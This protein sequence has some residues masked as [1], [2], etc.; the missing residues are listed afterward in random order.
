M[1]VAYL[2]H[3]TELY[4]ANRSLI[5]LV[6][7]L[8]A[9]GEV[10]PLVV[11]PREGPLLEFLRDA[12]I[13][14][15]VFPFEPWMSERRYSGRFY[16]KLKQWWGYEQAAMTRA[17]NNV[18]T[19]PGLAQ[20]VKA[21]RASLVH[22]NSAAVSVGAA[23]AREAGVPLVQHVREMPEKHYRLHLDMGRGAY[24]D[25]LQ[26]ADRVIAISHAAAEDLKR[27]APSARV[28]VAYNGVLRRSR[29]AEFAQQAEERW[30]SP[31]PIRFVMVGLLH[32]GKRYDEA[33]DAVRAV[34]AQGHDVRLSIAGGGRDKDLVAHIHRAGLQDVVELLGYVEDPFPLFRQAHALVMCS[35]DEAMGR[36]TVEAMAS[37]LPVIGHAS[38]ATP[39]LVRDGITGL[40]YTDGPEA[41]AAC[42]LELLADLH[43]AR[44]MGR[45]GMEE[46]AQ[47]FT[48]EGYATEVMNV[49]RDILPDGAPV[50]RP[51]DDDDALRT[52]GR[53]W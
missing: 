51:S 5:D 47:R 6:L 35:R 1:R 39:E 7:E 2:T 42:M 31:S 13:T 21:Q 32:P 40:L 28:T 14:C 16:H 29:Y 50:K 26:S 4:G 49:Y 25:A 41:L 34:R 15:A 17:R 27:Y 20:W 8:R 18:L 33:V 3:Y 53:R 36:V 10:E 22:A 11:A 9:R 19:V 45:A 46:A 43:R 44:S 37:G 30:L 12:G 52:R 48:V 24:G 23:V 38:G